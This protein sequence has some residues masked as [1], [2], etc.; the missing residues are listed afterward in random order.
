MKLWIFIFLF[1]IL[2]QG[3]RRGVGVAGQGTGKVGSTL[4]NGL[5][6]LIKDLTNDKV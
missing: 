3:R 2:V 5:V 6:T 1:L 4:G